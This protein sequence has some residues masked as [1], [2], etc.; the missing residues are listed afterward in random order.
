[1]L[2]IT[3]PPRVARVLAELPCYAAGG[4][5]AGWSVRAS[6]LVAASAVSRCSCRCPR[7]KVCRTIPRRRRRLRGDGRRRARDG[8]HASPAAGPSLASRGHEPVPRPASR[9]VSSPT[10]RPPR[11]AVPPAG[12]DHWNAV[13]S[14]RHAPRRRRAARRSRSSSSPTAS[15]PRARRQ[16]R[17]HARAAGA[18]V[19]LVEHTD[20][21]SSLARCSTARA[22]RSIARRALGS[23]PRRRRTRTRAARA[24]R[25]ARRRAAAA[26]RCSARSTA[27]ATTRRPAPARRRRA[28]AAAPSARSPVARAAIGRARRALARRRQRAHAARGAVR[29]PA[30]RRCR[31]GGGLHARPAVDW[32]PTAPASGLAMANSA[33]TGSRRSRRRSRRA[34]AAP[35]APASHRMVGGVVQY[36]WYQQW[37]ANPMARAAPLSHALV[38]K[39]C[40]HRV[41]RRRHYAAAPPQSPTAQLA[42]HSVRRP[43]ARHKLG[44]ARLPAKRASHRW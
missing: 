41:V 31:A 6:A 24:G 10:R 17:A 11:C 12:A 13:R 2:T 32:V 27:E 25:G 28:C 42:R 34:R 38:V 23:A 22:C 4:A 36:G 5:W 43:H 39:G 44:R 8:A 20:R 16:T 33:T 18:A 9:G 35:A 1:M 19:V 40:G 7:P 29:A 3:C 15:P 37:S 14:A 21:S 26:P 30:P